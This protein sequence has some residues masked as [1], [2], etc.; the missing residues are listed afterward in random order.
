MSQ[1]NSSN[2]LTLNDYL[3]VNKDNFKTLDKKQKRLKYS[4]YLLRRNNEKFAPTGGISKT[5]IKNKQAQKLPRNLR[6]S[7]SSINISECTLN[8]IRASIDPFDVS[9]KDPCIPDAV[10]V[11]SYKFNVTLMATM[12]IG[13]TGIGY[14]IFNPYTASIN[15]NGATASVSDYPLVVTTSS[16]NYPDFNFQPTDLGSQVIGVNSNS[17][18]N[19]ASYASASQRVVGAGI[20]AFYTGNVLNQAGVVTTLQNDGNKE[21]TFPLPIPFVQSNP[22][23]RV[24]SN[25]K[26]SRCYVS[27][28]A[29]NM[30]L[31]SYSDFNVS[32]PSDGSSLTSYAIAIIVSGAQP[33]TT[34]QIVGKVYF[35]AQIPGMGSSL[36]E[37]DPIGFAGF[38]T[39]RAALKATD[40]PTDDLKTVLVGTA[41]AIGTTI[42]G[43]APEV[44]TALGAMAGQPVLGRMLGSAVSSTLNTLMN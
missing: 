16:Y 26:D 2:V 18:F 37:S 27:Y 22:R 41:K 14:A 3:E 13:L 10:C 8:Y 36:S 28:Y 25:Q 17:Y 33:N 31:L 4:E 7:M 5:R 1:I 9:I 21:F 35:E 23:S 39:A 30:Q 40:N 6:P 29:T 32:R 44:G 34:F 43:F 12:N 38:Q 11:P 15:D 42:S 20:E 24:C 19:D